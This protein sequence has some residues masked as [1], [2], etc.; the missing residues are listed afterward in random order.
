M[1]NHKICRNF[2][3]GMNAKIALVAAVLL[4]LLIAGMLIHDKHDPDF[5]SSVTGNIVASLN[6]QCN[7]VPAGLC[8]G[9]NQVCIAKASGVTNVHLG[10]VADSVYDNC[11]CC[12]GEGLGNVCSGVYSVFGRISSPDNAHG[13]SP[14]LSSLDYSVSLCLGSSTGS[15]SS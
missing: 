2:C 5:G 1:A 9:A 8:T 14:E 7:V 6:A 15:V 12:S 11:V 4:V 13:E 3:F 10:T